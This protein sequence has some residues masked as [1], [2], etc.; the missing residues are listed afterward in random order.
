MYIKDTKEGDSGLKAKASKAFGQVG[1][2]TVD[3]VS[4]RGVSRPR[5]RVRELTTRGARQRF[6]RS[7]RG[8][9]LRRLGARL[10]VSSVPSTVSA[11]S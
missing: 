5:R 10:R 3:I 11:T 4:E 1:R 2:P 7:S 6:A 8:L 9:R